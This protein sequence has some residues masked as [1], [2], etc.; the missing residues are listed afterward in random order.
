MIYVATIRIGVHSEDVF[1]DADMQLFED[2]TRNRIE[3][4]LNVRSPRSKV[5]FVEV[6]TKLQEDEED[7]T[8]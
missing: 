4:A 1:D 6:T 8:V 7:E 5:A 3:D 2:E